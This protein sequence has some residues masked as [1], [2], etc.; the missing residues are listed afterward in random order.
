MAEESTASIEV[1]LLLSDRKR[2]VRFKA[3][4]DLT[5]KINLNVTPPTEEQGEFKF[6]ITFE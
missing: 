6:E 2:K 4:A 1:E 3:G 5:G